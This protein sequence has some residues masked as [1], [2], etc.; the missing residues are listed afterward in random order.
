MARRPV[1]VAGR[2]PHPL[3]DPP[4]RDPRGARALGLGTGLSLVGHLALL[5]AL[6]LTHFRLP[7]APD[8]GVV[9]VSL[10]RGPPMEA[11]AAP[12]AD[13]TPAPPKLVKPVKV[14]TKP[15][16]T[17]RPARNVPSPVRAQAA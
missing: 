11:A 13:P 8:Q 3:T 5:L 7:S 1:H 10:V 16:R 6:L 2:M 14:K 17:T 9:S 15:A 4:R 12:A